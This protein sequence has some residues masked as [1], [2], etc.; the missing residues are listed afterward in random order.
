MAG[1]LDLTGSVHGKLTVVSRAENAKGGKA[2]WNC[3]CACGGVST[4]SGTDLRSG[5]SKSC[6]CVF[7]SGAHK[8][9]HGHHRVG[10]QT[11]IYNTWC[12]MK[13]RCSDPTN[14][15]WKD[16][17]GRGIS[18]CNKWV[19]SFENFLED[20]GEPPFGLTLDRVNNDGDYSPENCRWADR[21]TQRRN[22]R[23]HVVEVE[24]DGKKML[25]KDAAQHLKIVSVMAAYSRMYRGWSPILAVTTPYTRSDNKGYREFA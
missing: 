7:A 8:V 18:V 16:Y 6:G 2:R 3:L 20:M 15:Q 10:K 17:G 12:N 24:I 9:T 5:H 21:P 25:L 13:R 22:G 11:K 14:K 4:A 1:L 19:N 23:G